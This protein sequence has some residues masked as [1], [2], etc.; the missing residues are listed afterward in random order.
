[1]KKEWQ[2]SATVKRI[3]ESAAILFFARATLDGL[4]KRSKM[5]PANVKE[6]PSAR[7]PL[8]GLTAGRN[9]YWLCQ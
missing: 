9:T 6:K 8:R 4:M 5:H 7:P 1:M 2:N 3:S